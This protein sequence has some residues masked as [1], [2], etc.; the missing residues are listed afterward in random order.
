MKKFIG[1]FKTFISRGNVVDMAVGIIVG[2][3]FTAIVNSLSN[4]IL[5]PVTNFLLSLVLG[6]ESAT[7]LYTY[8]RKVEITEEILNEAG[9]TVTRTVPDLTQSIYI[10]WGSFIN[11]VISFFLIALVLFIF[12]K[13]VN[14]FREEHEEW[15][16]AVAEKTLDRAERKEL[17]AA[18]IKIRDKQAVKNYFERKKQAQIE[19]EKAKAAEEAEKLRL[20]RLANPTV[21]DLLK[22][23]LAELRSNK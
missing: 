6:T 5:K 4:H 16:Q 9:E 7:E 17:R 12:I 19:A 2:G 11:A 14:K 20:E 3:S 15:K 18:G 10:D 21:E 23:I 1:E 8:L 22:D 13:A